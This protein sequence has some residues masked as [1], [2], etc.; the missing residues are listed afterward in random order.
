[1]TSL[2]GNGSPAGMAKNSI[3]KGYD[4]ARSNNFTPEM[5]KLFSHLMG[6]LGPDSFLSKLA[7]GDQSLFEQMEAPAWRDFG[8]AQGQLASRFSGQAGSP[9]MMSSRNSSG[10]ANEANQQSSN[11]AQDLQSKRLGLQK[12]AIQQMLGLGNSLLSQRPY[13]DKFVEHEPSFWEKILGSVGGGIG[14]G[15]SGGLSGGIGD[16]IGGWFK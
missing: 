13:N 11:F 9:R 1:M 15:I 3:P 8:A 5:M 2:T 6:Q 16:L 10:F 12:D 7:G 4:L 14:K